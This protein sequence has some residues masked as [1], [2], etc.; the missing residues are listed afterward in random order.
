MA[1]RPR[2]LLVGDD[3]KLLQ[4]RAMILGVRFEVD[5]SARLSEAQHLMQDHPFALVIVCQAT[6]TWGR[7]AEFASRQIPATKILAI[8]STDDDSPEWADE[9]VCYRQGPYEILKICAEMFGIKTKT[10]S[11]GFSTL[12]S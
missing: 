6:R 11:R 1:I 10:K 12:P 3:L 4:T 5:I 9:I 8:T 7:F 2:I